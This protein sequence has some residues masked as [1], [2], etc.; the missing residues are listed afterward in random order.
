MRCTEIEIEEASV[1]TVP[2]K[3]HTPSPEEYSR[4]CATHL[5]YRNWCPICAQ[6][7]KRN[8]AHQRKKAE[9]KHKHVPV[10]SMDYMRIADVIKRLGRSKIA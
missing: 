1:P 3:I 10:I 7:K 2:A 9:N 5:P 8:P 4:H 6:A